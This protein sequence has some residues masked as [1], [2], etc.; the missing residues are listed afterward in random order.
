MFISQHWEALA[1]ILLSVVAIGIA[2]WSSRQTS[3]QATRQIESIKELT[4]LQ[5]ETAITEIEMEIS[6]Q[7]VLLQ[8][9]HEE[10]KRSNDIMS[11]NQLDF[12]DLMQKD[13]EAEKPFRDLKYT[14]SYLSELRK[15]SKRMSEIKLKLNEN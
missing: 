15:I 8:R 9:A 1:S 4:K 5:I 13:F 14:H 7:S 11:V 6:K 3:M 2:I 12:R 10:Q